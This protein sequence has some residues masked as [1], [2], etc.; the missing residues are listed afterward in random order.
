MCP[1]GLSHELRRLILEEGRG[2]WGGMESAN[3]TLYLQLIHYYK[4]KVVCVWGG[5]GGGGGDSGC[6]DV[7]YVVFLC[8]CFSCQE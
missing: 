4:L 6:L 1:S 3:H 2:N 8:P 5:G 7:H